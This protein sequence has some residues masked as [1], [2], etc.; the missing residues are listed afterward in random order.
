MGP[1]IAGF[2]CF[3]VDS[4][5]LLLWLAIIVSAVMSWLFA[6]DVINYRD[7]E[8][9]GTVLHHSLAGW[10]RHHPD[11]RPA[12]HLGHPLLHP[13]GQLPGPVSAAG[14]LLMHPGHAQVLSPSGPSA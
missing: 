4:V 8:T 2:I 14:R 5:F 12:D 11:H 10:H 6:F 3:L 7:P 1:A 13:A 9:K